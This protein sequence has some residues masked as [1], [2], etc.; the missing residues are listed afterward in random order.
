MKLT[1]LQAKKKIQEISKKYLLKAEILKKVLF[2][3]C[4]GMSNTYISEFMLIN[5]NTISKYCRILKR[6]IPDTEIFELMICVGVIGD[7]FSFKEKYN[8]K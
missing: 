2:G 5:Q 6:E 8:I 1:K 4:S 7:G 3:K